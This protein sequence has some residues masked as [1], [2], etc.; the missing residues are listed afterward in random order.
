[1]KDWASKF[2]CREQDCCLCVCVTDVDILPSFQEHFILYF[3]LRCFLIIGFAG[4]WH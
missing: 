4:D 2:T 3:L 1:M